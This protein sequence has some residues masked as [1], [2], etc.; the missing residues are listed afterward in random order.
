[1]KRLIT[2][3]VTGALAF[4]FL[5]PNS[6]S[7]VEIKGG[8]KIGASSAKL[9]GDDVEDLTDFLGED[10]KS[11]IGL[12][13]GGFITFNITE[14]FAIQPEVLY[15]MKGSKYE[16]E[17]FGETLKVW[18]K[19]DYLEIPVLV[20]IMVPT[21]GGVKPC[22][23][24]GPVLAMKL[25]GKV[26]FEYGADSKEEDIEEDMKSTDFGL[27]IGAGVDIGFGAPGM[28]KITLDIRYSLGLST[29]SD[30]EDEDIK[31][32][33]FSLMVGFSF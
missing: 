21:P 16:E 12:C 22:L 11:R 15:T 14:M 33:V 29:I 6:S 3:I 2:I 24:A 32:G 18:I 19:L 8:L 26:K 31:N 23:F 25:S 13:A 20:K 5:L 4:M 30:F 9:H 7:A 17:I 28:G 27:V 10:Q 1:M